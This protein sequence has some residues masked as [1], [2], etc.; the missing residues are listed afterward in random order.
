M[1]GEKRIITS[2]IQVADTRGEQPIVIA[3]GFDNK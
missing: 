3:E 2:A 1:P